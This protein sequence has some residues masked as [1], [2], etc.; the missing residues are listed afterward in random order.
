MKY[1]KP[2]EI[3]LHES[4]IRQKFKELNLKGP[5]EGDM[6]CTYQ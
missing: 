5:K 4:K 1:K 3:L 6:E 2:E